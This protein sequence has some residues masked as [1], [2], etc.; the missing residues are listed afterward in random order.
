MNEKFENNKYYGTFEINFNKKKILS[1][2]RDKNI[3]HSRIIEKNVLFIPIYINLEKDSILLFNENPFYKNW[4]N[5]ED[6][7]FLLNYILQNED[8]DDYKLIKERIKFMGC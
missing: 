1:F 8:L 2:L 4:N 7:H 6:K 5:E 3:F